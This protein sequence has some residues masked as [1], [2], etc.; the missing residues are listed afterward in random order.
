MHRYQW[1]V[2]TAFNRL[3]CIFLRRLDIC[4]SASLVR[5]GRSQRRNAFVK[6][7]KK[8]ERYQSVMGERLNFPVSH[9][10]AGYWEWNHVTVM[11]N[12]HESVNAPFRNSRWSLCHCIYQTTFSSTL[13]LLLLMLV[14]VRLLNIKSN[15]N[16]R[17]FQRFYS[18]DNIFFQCSAVMQTKSIFQ[19][20][21]PGEWLHSMPY[22]KMP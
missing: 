9:C 1:S 22:L 15:V 6:K 14:F 12:T 3:S 17:R 20:Y 21:I 18:K 19:G 16:K 13:S 7:K 11:S 4:F 10:T 5:F 2:S 8:K